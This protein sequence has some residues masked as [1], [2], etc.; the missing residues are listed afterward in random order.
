MQRSELQAIGVPATGT[1]CSVVVL[2]ASPF[3]WLPQ[4]LPTAEQTNEHT[5]TAVDF[6][7]VCLEVLFSGTKNNLFLA[8]WHYGGLQRTSHCCER[9]T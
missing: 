1:P 6:L 7:F 5:L 8:C 4:L 9:F 3:Q 2:V